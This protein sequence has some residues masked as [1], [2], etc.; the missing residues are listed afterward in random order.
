V[1]K[2]G[3]FALAIGIGL[4]GNAA[5]DDADRNEEVK[6][7]VYSG[8]FEKNN[9]GLK[10]EQSFVAIL[11]RKSFDSIF[12]VARVIGKKPELVPEGAFKDR[13][14]IAT[15]KRGGESW[16]YEVDKVTLD[17]KGTLTLRYQASSKDG[18][19]A[20]FA[21]PL[22]LSVPKGDYKRILFVENGK[23]VGK[24]ELDAKK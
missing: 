22:I 8:Y 14:V 1:P 23:E 9:S 16:T 10:G 20:K 18:G 19:G 13:L 11:G 6:F 17:D 7:D 4:A 2:L 12:G 15:M 21:S 3:L 5:A 24:A